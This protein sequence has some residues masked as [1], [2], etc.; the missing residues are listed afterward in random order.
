MKRLALNWLMGLTMLAFALATCGCDQSSDA[1]AYS[2]EDYLDDQAIDQEEP[3]GADSVAKPL[4]TFL[5]REKGTSSAGDLLMLT[6]RS[7]KTFVARKMIV[8]VTTPC[9]PILMEGKY[10]WSTSG[11]TRYV[12]LWVGT[13][14]DKLAYKQLGSALMLRRVNSNRWFVLDQVPSI[15]VCRAIGTANEGWYDAETSQLVCKSKCAGD[16]GKCGA[17]GSKSEGWYAVSGKGCGGSKLVRWQL[18]DQPNPPVCKAIGS[19]SEGW[20][21][22]D[23]G[24]LI[25]WTLCADQTAYCGAIGS[26]SEGWYVD[27]KRGCSPASPLIKWTDCSR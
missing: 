1:T 23:T 10:T 27:G 16:L 24:S 7:N 15:P 3:D 19:K 9:K 17:I 22:A 6:L 14:K 2:E 21:D 8:C 5:V 12:N 4:G 13:V 11:S 26:K 25:C 20:Y 18:C